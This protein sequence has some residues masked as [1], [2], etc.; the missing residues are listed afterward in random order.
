MFRAG[1]MAGNLHDA[2]AVEERRQWA[3]FVAYYRS[4]VSRLP[5]DG[6]A[7]QQFFV[8]VFASAPPFWNIRHFLELTE[9]DDTDPLLRTNHLVNFDADAGVC[10]HPFDFLPEG[11]EAA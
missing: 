4:C 9:H 1:A 6:V 2:N 3:F 5:P 10:A 8:G 7:F 11:R